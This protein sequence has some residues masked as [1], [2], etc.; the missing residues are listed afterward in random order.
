MPIKFEVSGVN[1]THGSSTCAIQGL[2]LPTNS[3]Q[4]TYVPITDVKFVQTQSLCYRKILN[5][6]TAAPGRA[7]LELHPVEP[8]PYPYMRA[9][10]RIDKTPVH[11]NQII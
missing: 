5:R 7:R 11:Y 1:F 4:D 6:H 3:D 10:H 8:T 2:T 9:K